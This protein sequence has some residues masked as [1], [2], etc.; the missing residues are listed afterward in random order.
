MYGAKSRRS[1]NRLAPSLRLEQHLDFQ[2]QEAIDELHQPQDAVPAT[3]AI[4]VLSLMAT[5]RADV[6]GEI[7]TPW[8]YE[9]ARSYRSSKA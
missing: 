2:C 7:P 1:R 8:T 6:P 5:I 3:G 9:G 4:F